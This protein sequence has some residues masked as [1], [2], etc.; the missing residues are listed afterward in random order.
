MGNV[1]VIASV[2]GIFIQLIPINPIY[3]PVL[4]SNENMSQY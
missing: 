3:K 2:N 4:V 1:R